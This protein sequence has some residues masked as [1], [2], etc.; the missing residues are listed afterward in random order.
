MTRSPTHQVHKEGVSALAPGHGFSDAIDIAR[1][2]CI[3]GV[4]YVHAWAGIGIAEIHALPLQPGTVL[5]WTL[6][7]GFARSSV[8]LLSVISG[9]LVGSSVRQRSY[10]RFVLNKAVSLVAPM[11]AWNLIAVLFVALAVVSIG[12][13]AEFQPVGMALV[14][15][16]LHL[17]APGKFNVQNVFLRD[18]F[19]CMLAAPLLVRLPSRLLWGIAAVTAVWA[20]AGWDLY[21]LLRPQILLFFLFGILARRSDFVQKLETVS[22][23]PV[24]LIF[25]GMAAI[26][27]AIAIWGQEYQ[28]NHAH[29]ILLFDNMFRVVAAVSFWWAA[30]ALARSRFASLLLRLAP[31]SF[32][33]FCS[34]VIVLRAIGPAIGHFTGQMGDP[35]WPVFFVLQPL[36]ALIGA[37]LIG[38]GIR[39]CAPALAKL[40]SGGR[41]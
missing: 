40:L 33:L 28:A 3:L 39:Y 15:E 6:G 38:Q 21:V 16:V 11:A 26:R 34:H 32:L 4:V 29:L 8:P 37:V 30:L 10:G 14:N 1:L 5:Y 22:K 13:K 31:Y 17:T 36:I 2:I 9:W 19:I 7:E 18:V 35:L 23:A 12:F 27:V 41:L 20:V 24:L 25:S